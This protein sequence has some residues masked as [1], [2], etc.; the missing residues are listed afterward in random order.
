MPGRRDDSIS[1]CQAERGEVKGARTLLS[2]FFFIFAAAPPRFGSAGRSA[3]APLPLRAFDERSGGEAGAVLLFSFFFNKGN[4]FLGK[5]I[6]FID[7]FINLPV[8]G[9]DSVLEHG[10]FPLPRLRA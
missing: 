5:A 8:G 6:E 2:A 3:R 10:P 1:F 9:G 7:E 4:F